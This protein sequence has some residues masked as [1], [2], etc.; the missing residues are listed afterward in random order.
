MVSNWSSASVEVTV[1]S[2]ESWRAAEVS[3]VAGVRLV[4]GEEADAAEV[5]LLRSIGRGSGAVIGE[6]EKVT[7]PGRSCE[8]LTVQNA[9]K[10]KCI[11]FSSHRGQGRDRIL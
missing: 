5:K 10:M 7:W 3:G 4:A 1:D 8:A 11:Y 9:W 2:L 6:R